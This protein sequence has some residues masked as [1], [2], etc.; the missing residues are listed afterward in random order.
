[1]FLTI[2]RKSVIAALLVAVTIA[3]A[4]AVSFAATTAVS[5]PKIGRTIVIDAGHGGID[6]GV[7][8]R[9]SGVKEAEVNLA[10]ARSLRHFFERGGYEV[11]MTR[12]S[13][14]G[15]YGVS[16]TN[17][18]RSDMERRRD[19]IREAAPDMV[20]SVHQNFYPL[21]SVSGAQVFYCDGGENAGEEAANAI[22]A[23]LNNL[24]GCNRV[25]KKG[26]YYVVKCTSYPSVIVKCGFLS[27]PTEEKKLVTAAYQEKV[28][29][30]IY[31]AVHG[32]LG[33][34]AGC[35]PCA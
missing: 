11:V 10:I 5:V 6:G 27:N 9:Q 13:A 4:V 14:D 29:R 12:T 18:K 22:Q 17:K 34:A 35:D 28:A 31:S 16:S 23:S 15:L 19:I 26:D 25:A 7:V 30:A 32:M 3:V 21:S 33:E 8:G 20:I 1:M 24:L 2:K